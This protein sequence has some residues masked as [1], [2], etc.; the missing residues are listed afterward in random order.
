MQGVIRAHLHALAAAD[1]T[2]QERIL[3]QR[4]RRP[5]QPLVRFRA[6]T[7]IGTQQGKRGCAGCQSGQY[8][9]PLEIC[10]LNGSGHKRRREKTE[11]N[12]TFRAIGDAV[13]CT[14]RIR[15]SA[16][17]HRE[18]D[19]PRPGSEAGNGCSPRIRQGVSPTQN[20]P[21]RDQANSAPSGTARGTISV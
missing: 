17:V 20:G 16:T 13:S 3:R 1:T 9:A 5:D 8:L 14:E 10:A 7:G 4:R 19:R 21:A 2:R 18:W 12:P 11:L 15:L 6:Q